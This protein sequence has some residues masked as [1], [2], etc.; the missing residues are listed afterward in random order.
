VD[1][2]LKTYK[3]APGRQGPVCAESEQTLWVKADQRK[4]AQVL[5]NLISNAYKYSPDGGEV[6]ISYRLDMIDGLAW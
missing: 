5:C 2:A 6:C 4:L 3:P 1:E